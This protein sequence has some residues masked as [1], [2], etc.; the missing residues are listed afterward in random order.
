MNNPAT[1]AF[2]SFLIAFSFA[3]HVTV[4]GKWVRTRKLAKQVTIFGIVYCDA[5]YENT[6]TNHSYFLQGAHVQARCGSINATSVTNRQG[7]Y[8][9]CLPIGVISSCHISLINNSATACNVP[10]VNLTSNITL[11]SS[12]GMGPI[13]V[14]APLSYVPSGGPMSCHMASAKFVMPPLGNPFSGF[15]FPPLPPIPH[16]SFPFPF[17]P[18]IPSWF[19]PPPP[20]SQFSL[21]SPPSWF[22]F[23]R[24]PSPPHYPNPTVEP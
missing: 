13:Y 5:C 4:D 20:P 1:C 21:E 12:N 8:A 2:L 17:R 9:I 7:I 14:V 16:L 24:P 19:L 15:P 10:R 23:F 22:P 18:P 6:F 11:E 3:C